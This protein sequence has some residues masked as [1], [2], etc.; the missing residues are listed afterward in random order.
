[1]EYVKDRPGRAGAPHRH[2]PRVAR[3]QI[4]QIADVKADPEY[5]WEEASRLG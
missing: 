2:R 1:M 5:G 4:V 3:R